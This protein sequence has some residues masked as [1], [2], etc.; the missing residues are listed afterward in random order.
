MNKCFIEN[1][2]PTELYSI[3]AF[4]YKNVAPMGLR[5][6]RHSGNCDSQYYLK[7]INFIVVQLRRS[8]IFVAAR[9]AED[10]SPIG[11]AFCLCNMCN[12]LDEFLIFNVV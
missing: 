11:A 2:A 5:T 1:A 7:I 8:G 10:K 12:I 6:R 9:A 3:F 4:G